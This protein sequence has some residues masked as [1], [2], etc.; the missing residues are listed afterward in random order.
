MKLTIALIATALITSPGY[1][2][3]CRD[4]QGRE[5]NCPTSATSAGMG[6]AKGKDGKCR[7]ISGPR[8]GKIVKCP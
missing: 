7:W 8:K 1:S 4:G 6:V 5:A 2:A 3:A